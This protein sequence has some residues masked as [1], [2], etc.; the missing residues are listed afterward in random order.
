MFPQHVIQYRGAVHLRG[1]LTLDRVAGA[2]RDH[3]AAG[4][5]GGMDRSID[6]NIGYAAVGDRLP[7]HA[8]V[9]DI[10]ADRID[11]RA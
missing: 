10:S 8:L 1:K 9:S 5:A 6:R 4:D 11:P 7:Q 2:Q 3:T